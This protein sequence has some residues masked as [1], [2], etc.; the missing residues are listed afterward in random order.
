[1]LL[2]LLTTTTITT[3]TLNYDEDHFVQNVAPICTSVLAYVYGMD[4]ESMDKVFMH[5]LCSFDFTGKSK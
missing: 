5:A 3:T 1:M 2:L 4:E